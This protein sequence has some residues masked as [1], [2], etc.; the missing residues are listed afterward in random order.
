MASMFGGETG[1]PLT[2][3][4]QSLAD[5]VRL[6]QDKSVCRFSTDSKALRAAV[7]AGIAHSLGQID[8]WM[9]HQRDCNS[10]EHQGDDGISLGHKG[11]RFREE[12][13]SYT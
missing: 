12:S 1:G 7:R 2:D 11:M 6:G 5:E 13:A 3:S 9:P 8:R 4:M 10:N